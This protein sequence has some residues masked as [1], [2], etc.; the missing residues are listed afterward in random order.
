MDNLFL[1]E[2]GTLSVVDYESKDSIKKRIKY[3][4]YTQEHTYLPNDLLFCLKQ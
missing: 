3:V 4:N 2:D 1:L